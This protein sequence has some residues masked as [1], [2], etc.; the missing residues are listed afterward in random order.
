MISNFSLAIGIN[1]NANRYKVKHEYEYFRYDGIMYSSYVNIP[2]LL[3]YK[4]P[5]TQQFSVSAGIFLGY[6]VSTFDRFELVTKEGFSLLNSN[7][8]Y[9]I[10]EYKVTHPRR[11]EKENYGLILQ[12]D[13]EY[14]LNQ[15]L[16]AVVFGRFNYG[17][18]NTIKKLRYEYNNRIW[19]TYDIALGFGLNI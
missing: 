15:R 7:P 6:R 9:L 14:K 8:N 12:A 11:F 5:T 13:Y 17:L 10:N 18:K 19:K 1:Y 4:I 16:S 3:N 2:L